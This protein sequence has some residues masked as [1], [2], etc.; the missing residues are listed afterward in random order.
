M[1]N[2]WRQI[3]LVDSQNKIFVG[4]G[5]VILVVLI[6]EKYENQPYYRRFGSVQNIFVIYFYI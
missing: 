4:G 1:E 6:S 5:E 2:N 3:T